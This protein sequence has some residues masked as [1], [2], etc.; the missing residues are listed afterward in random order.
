ML[1]TSLLAC[2]K[3]T[4]D[5][6]N[7]ANFVKFIARNCWFLSVLAIYVCNMHNMATDQ[8]EWSTYMQMD[9]FSHCIKVFEHLLS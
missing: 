3:L 9:I 2:L 1:I 6:F 7:L 4:L 5:I 8:T